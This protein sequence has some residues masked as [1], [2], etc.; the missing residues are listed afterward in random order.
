MVTLQKIT[1][2]NFSAVLDIKMDEVQNR[3]VAPNVVSLAQAWLY[4]DMAR[5]F[6]VCSDKTVVGF[7]MM[8]WDESERTA[9]IWRFMI[10][11][12]HQ[13]KGYGR[14]AME[15][16]IQMARASKNID[17]LHL[18]YVEGNTVARELYYSLGFRENGKVEDGEIIMT[19]PLTKRPKLGVVTADGDDADE[20]AALIDSEKKAGCAI[21]EAF[22]TK[23]SRGALIAKK[24][25]KRLT[26]LG[27][28]IGL[29]AGDELWL[30]RAYKR[31]AA[32]ARA[33]L[34]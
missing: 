12:E 18:D 14:K 25:L 26:L 9:G 8:D 16:A 1:E 19:L 2:E 10:A 33:A 17:M 32:R 28:T 3:F 15:K 20:L 23:R 34:K 6:A 5:P 27:E 7:L 13:H 30:A 29:A 4:G 24:R 22:K 11:P 21:P 31:Y